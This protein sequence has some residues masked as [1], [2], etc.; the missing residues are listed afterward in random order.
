[1]KIPPKLRYYIWSGILDLNLPIQW[2]LI[3]LCTLNL[4]ITFTNLNVLCYTYLSLSRRLECIFIKKVTIF[5]T[6]HYALNGQKSK[7]NHPKY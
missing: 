7:W 5:L 4:D 3:L 1:M 6:V 2:L